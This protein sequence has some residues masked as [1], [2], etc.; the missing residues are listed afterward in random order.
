[1]RFAWLVAILLTLSGSAYAQMWVDNATIS[2]TTTLSAGHVCYTDGRDIAC[3]S[4]A[5]LASGLGSADRIVSGS[6]LAVANSATGYISLTTGAT[7]WGYLSSGVNYLPTLKTTTLSASTAI[8]V[9]SN[10]LTCTT[11]ISGTMRYSATSSTLE[12]CN[13]SAWTSMGPSAT[14]VPAFLVNKNGTN[15]TVSTNTTTKLTWSNEVYDTNNNFASDKFTPAI[16]GKYLVMA[17]VLCTDSTGHCMANIYKNGSV[18]AQGA[19][20]SSDPDKTGFISI[21]VDMNGSTDYLEAYGYNGGGT[22][23]SG[24]A[25]NTFF[26][27]TLIASGNGLA[28]SG[29]ST[30]PGGNNTEIQYNNSGA[31]GSSSNFTYSGGLLTLTGTVTTTNV[32]A[33]TISTTSLWVGGQQITGSSSADRIVSGSTSVMAQSASSVISITTA[34]V[35]TGYFNSN[36]VLTVP[37]ISATSNQT[38][39][40]TL[41]ASGN[42]G[43]GTTAPSTTLTVSGT[44]WAATY[45]FLIRTG[46][47]APVSQSGTGGGGSLTGSGTNTHVAYWTGATGLSGDSG[48]TWNGT[49]LTATNINTSGGTLNGVNI[50]TGTA[51]GTVSATNGYFGSVSATTVQVAQSNNACNS[52]NV[53][54]I[55]RD[56]STNKLQVCLDH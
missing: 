22:T 17:A 14:S 11:G 21:I 53:G 30:S 9:G 39:V 28:G 38:S 18:V 16:A 34:G 25:I 54:M 33:N 2:P 36:G 8:Q 6:L 27:G 26:T 52:S 19:A 50:G 37:G 42:V 7:N 24:A 43:I 56:P 41:Y 5:P 13:G 15:Q 4:S 45:A 20:K 32:Y 29:G 1:M 49:A 48:F 51:A 46:L 10:A 55:R 3:D 23:I 40:T 31:F 47:A 35:T 44:V 12:Y